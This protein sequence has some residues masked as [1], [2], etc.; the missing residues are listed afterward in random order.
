MH[1]IIGLEGFIM[2]RVIALLVT[3]HLILPSVGHAAEYN[4]G[5]LCGGVGQP[6]TGAFQRKDTADG[7]ASLICDG[8]EWRTVVFHGVNGQKIALGDNAAD[9]VTTASSYIA[10]G[11][12]ALSGLTTNSFAIAIGNNALAKFSEVAIPGGGRT[13][14]AIGNGALEN[15]TTGSRNITLGR[16]TGTGV[17]TGVGNVLIGAAV[18][19]FA[20][21]FSDNTIIGTTGFYA[22]GSGG[23]NNVAM[24]SGVL[25]GNNGSNNVV[26]GTGAGGSSGTADNS[27]FIGRRAGGSIETGDNNIFLGFQTGDATTTGGNN[28]IIGHDIDATT[29][30]ASNELNIG[31]AIYGD[32][33]NGYIGI[34]N[35]APDVE[36]D[37]TG[38]IEFTGTITDV[39][40][41]RLKR[42]IK[43]IENAIA[44]IRK[45]NGVS[46]VMRNDPSNA[47][48]LGLIAQDVQEAFPQLVKERGEGVLSLNYQGMVGPL[49]EA[50]KELDGENQKLRKTI[51][52]LDARLKLL[53]GAKRPPLRGYNN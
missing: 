46:F 36:L 30:D 42:K 16:Q 6:G 7:F 47:V 9:D 40:D 49:I 21:N 32:L 25:S 14:Y 20:G 37:V 33:T 38:N 51:Q 19:Q 24:G 26:L 18:G 52:E 48:E 8:T 4:D 41:R 34:A 15:L 13:N 28:I 17:T 27:V 1:T 53:E 35:T 23:S 3:A 2:R 22:P 31:N 45:L 39:S 5:D 50:V 11:K 44:G 12:N 10:I 43:P 29:A